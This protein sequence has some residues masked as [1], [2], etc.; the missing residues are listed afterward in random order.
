M[1]NFKTCERAGP[2]RTQK[3]RGMLT[4]KSLLT[5][6]P[7]EEPAYES[8]SHVTRWKTLQQM[9]EQYAENPYR[10]LEVEICV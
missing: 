5:A 1:C 2:V 4:K 3:V 8:P 9:A 6:L 10:F 7:D